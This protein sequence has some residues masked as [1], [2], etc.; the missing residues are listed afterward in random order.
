MLQTSV[1]QF[2]NNLRQYIENVIQTHQPLRVTR[3]NGENFMVISEDDWEREQE[4]LFILNNQALMQQIAE[5][6]ETHAQRKGRVATQEE[7]DE[8][9]SV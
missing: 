9:L 5:S 7:L 1:N 2:R 6:M 4:T 8:I 3:R